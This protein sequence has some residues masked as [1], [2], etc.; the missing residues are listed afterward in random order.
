MA[1]QMS[2]QCTYSEFHISSTDP[3]VFCCA[4]PSLKDLT[5][6]ASPGQISSP[7]A[8]MPSSLV[9]DNSN[10]CATNHCKDKP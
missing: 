3:T 8:S 9:F 4:C 5:K 2:N 7:K 10:E 6:P 1:C